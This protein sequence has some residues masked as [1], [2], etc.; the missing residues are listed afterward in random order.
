MPQPIKTIADLHEKG[1]ELNAAGGHEI[2]L[3]AGQALVV[4]Q[5]R[6]AR[7][8]QECIQLWNIQGVMSV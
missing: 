2:Q 4:D 1:C 6:G 3:H 7:R 5:V 8:N